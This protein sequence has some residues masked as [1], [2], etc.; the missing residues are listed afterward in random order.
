MGRSSWSQQAAAS[1]LAFGL[2]ATKQAVSVAA[3]VYP[4]VPTQILMP[5]ACLASS[6]CNGANLAYIFSQS[7]DGSV[8][9]SALNYSATVGS[10]TQ[11]LTVTNELPF[12]KEAPATTAF[13]A[14]RTSNGFVMVYSGACDDTTGSLWSF[15]N[16]L[17]DGVS[18]TWSRKKTVVS[19]SSGQ[20]PPRGPYFLGGT[21]AFSSSLAPTLDQP[22]IYTYG[23][24]CDSPD[25]NS[26][27]W[28]SSANY[29]TTM[30]SLAPNS[31]A[32]DTAY[33]LS[34]ASTSG[35]RT[36]L[37][38]FTLT[39]L[40]ASITNI[41][42]AVTQQDG[43]V[44]LGGH[45]QQAFINMSTAAV[46]NLPEQSWSYINISGPDATAAKLAA[47]AGETIPIYTRPNVQVESRSGHTAVLSEDGSSIFV[48]GG[49]V[50]NVN[51]PAQPQL[52]VLHLNQ[53]YSSWKW[54]IPKAQPQ[55]NA[56][57]GHGAATLPGN[58][59]MVFGGWEISTTGGGS[60]SKRQQASSPS[61]V[62]RFFNMTSMSWS[63]SYT[64]PMPGKISVVK[65]THDAPTDNNSSQSSPP[66]GLGLGLGLGLALLIG[67]L[68]AFLFWRIKL[69]KRRQARTEAANAM[70]LDAQYFVHD[71]DE[72]IERDEWYTSQNGGC[73]SASTD[74]SPGY[75]WLRGA[76]TSV[77]DSHPRPSTS[78]KAPAISRAMRGGYSPA[79]TR[80][81]AFVT[82]HGRI[83]PILEDDEEDH[84]H[85]RHQHHHSLNQPLTPTPEV[86]S[87][88][89][90]TPTTAAAAAVIRAPSNRSSATSI[91][92][93]VQK[94]YDPDV[95][96]WASDVD[97]ADILL[98]RYNTSRQGRISPTRLNSSRSA[99]LRDDESRTESNLSESNR[100]AADS[101]RPSSSNRRSAAVS[102]LG[103]MLL[104]NTE[105][106]KPGS[107]SSNSYNTARSGFGTLQAEAPALLEGRGRE[108]TTTTTLPSNQF[109]ED[110]EV[111]AL[112]PS[113]SKT[114]PRRGWLGSL[115]RVFSQSGGSSSLPSP[116]RSPTRPGPERYSSD[117]EFQTGLRGEL[118]KRKQGR[119]DWED[120]AQ[121][122]PRSGAEGSGNILAH[123]ENEWDI[124]KAVERRLVQVMFTVPKEKLRVVNGDEEP[125]EEQEP[126]K[127]MK[128]A[129]LKEADTDGLHEPQ[130]AEL[131]YPSCSS[132]SSAELQQ[133]GR[134][135]QRWQREEEEHRY[136]QA[137]NPDLLHVDLAE[138]RLSHSSDESGRRSSLAVFTAEAIT[139]ERPRTRVLQ[140]VDTIESRSQ[141][142]SPSRGAK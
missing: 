61:S 131:V 130:V 65:G 133:R 142:N 10:G 34:V 136:S 59:M 82:P 23:G 53:T 107:S 129:E 48:L 32:Q 101:L 36:P 14:A 71:T 99:G 64:N 30:M 132:L 35:P 56:V 18:N 15:A 43:F 44:V 81:N 126:E 57:F 98:D 89:F 1:A 29:T 76:S 62:L 92:D 137:D 75:E 45:T 118:L 72:M 122:A 20:A 40:P 80:F 83:H 79:E 86:Q 51:T 104:G 38:G 58:V 54:T 93:G 84:S 22:T 68:I 77:D 41:S 90:V 97:A 28:Q 103:G 19:S 4:Y 125:D 39:Q 2:V 120:D 127:M 135:Q 12:L 25:T 121:P 8:R 17:Q 27:G 88:P 42:G 73:Q 134:Q 49:W 115:G 94:Q 109:G 31:Q 138:P 102:L 78:R 11:L 74:Q 139:F 111:N 37:A 55:F 119:Q 106:P 67:V 21:L 128:R 87:D 108:E 69:R 110:E 140:M 13:N 141:S 5:T 124:E 60:T 105:H 66:L 52:A 95:Q 3:H 63:S 85:S 100:S 123:V 6:T 33:S 26:S 114:K 113:P 9:F 24:M 7:D 16:V 96:D 70:N 50:G 117:Y 47:R 112:P 116:E 46:W 91:P